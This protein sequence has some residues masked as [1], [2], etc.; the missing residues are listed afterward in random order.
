MSNRAQYRRF[1]E[2]IDE[3]KFIFDTV[4]ETFRKLCEPLVD[5]NNNNVKDVKVIWSNR[6]KTT[7]GHASNQTVITLSNA[8]W[9]RANYEQ[10][11]ETIVHET[12]HLIVQRRRD[13][14]IAHG[15]YFADYQDDEERDNYRCHGIAWQKAMITCGYENPKRCHTIKPVRRLFK[16]ACPCTVHL[17]KIRMHNKF[18]RKEIHGIRCNRCGEMCRFI[19]E[20]KE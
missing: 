15:N 4:E 18:M 13:K 1:A 2:K 6:L 11:K 9:E 20:M 3:H 17:I 14:I 12:C 16:Y 19:G 10:R 8:L 5:K 7:A